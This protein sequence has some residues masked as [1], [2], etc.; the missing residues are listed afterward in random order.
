MSEA[1]NLRAGA[2]ARSRAA[3]L[4]RSATQ[5][6]AQADRDEGQLRSVFGSRVRE[7]RKRRG[8]TG[9]DVAALAGVTHA[10]ISQIENGQ[11]TPSIS[12]MFRIAHALGIPIAELFESQSPSTDRVLRPEDWAV[13]DPDMSQDAVLALDPERR[14]ELVWSRIAPDT[15]S[16][17]QITH[18]AKIQV[19]FVLRGA[20]E[21]HVNGHDHVLE[22]HCCITFDGT[23]PHSWANTTSKPAEL[24]S[25]LYRPSA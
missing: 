10:F 21:L 23:S 4:S 7:A 25:F 5:L 20:V 22:Q 18:G 13:Y 15:Q 11:A 8:M 6:S 12:K 9:G 16:A 19:A 3:A 2:S 24:L 14:I 1:G 17:E